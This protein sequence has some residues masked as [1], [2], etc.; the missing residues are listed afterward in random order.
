MHKHKHTKCSNL[1]RP[2]L[3]L[4]S[5]LLQTGLQ[6]LK[7]TK[8]FTL[9][10]LIVTI[11]IL[12]I[13]WTI[14][15]ISL[16]WYST[17]ARDSTRI[18]DLSSMKTSLELFHLDAW[19]YPETTNGFVV[20]Y[21]WTEVWTQWTF[22]ETTKSNVEKLDKIPKDP[23]SEK[24][25]TYSLTKTK[26]EYELAWLIEWDLVYSPHPSPLPRG[27]GIATLFE[28]TNAAEILAKAIVT[29]NYNWVL[30]K[31]ETWT[32]CEVL[33]VPSIISSQWDTQTNLI[34]ILEDK[35]L[36][37]TGYNN[38][39]SN[40]KWSKYKTNEWFEF[41]TKKLV[42]YSDNQECKPLYD[43]E[44]PSARMQLVKN[45]QTAYSWTIIETSENIRWFVELDVSDNEA[46]NI[47]SATLLNN[48]MWWELVVK[49]LDT[50]ICDAWK[51]TEDWINCIS[52]KKNC[53]ITNWISEQTWNWNSWW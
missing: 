22:W 29:W 8:A 24:E 51:H 28:Q 36:V 26:Q 41:E 10:E 14:A 27:E 4:R 47:F 45:L 37:Y 19:K 31:S 50:L 25:Y 17:S 39:P 46:V 44:N 33:S 32:T 43:A 48:S 5:Q 6:R 53:T 40:Y 13:L 16:Q 18:S 35:N 1:F 12:A 20:T 9:I 7:S 52:D 3:N 11:A 30:F 42:V 49:K 34:E 15:F 38:L 21:S 23:L 2:V